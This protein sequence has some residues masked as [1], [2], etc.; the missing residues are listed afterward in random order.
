MGV[1]H[2]EQAMPRQ[3]PPGQVPAMGVSIPGGWAKCRP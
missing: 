3:L 1:R 2:V